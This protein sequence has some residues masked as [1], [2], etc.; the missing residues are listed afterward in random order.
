M[1]DIQKLI[2]VLLEWGACESLNRV[3]SRGVHERRQCLKCWNQILTSMV[4]HSVAQYKFS[5]KNQVKTVA[6]AVYVKISSGEQIVMDP[7]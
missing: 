1:S 5:Q 7:Q 4:G 3:S 6:S 2:Q